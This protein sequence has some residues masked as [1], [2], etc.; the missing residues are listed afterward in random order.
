MRSRKYQIFATSTILVLG[1][2]VSPSHADNA[3]PPK[4][5]SIEQV[6]NGPYSIGEIVTFRINYT[7]G[8]PGIRSIVI[9]GAGSNET[10]LASGTNLQNNGSD[11]YELVWNKDN[12]EKYM[13]LDPILVSAIVVPC[14]RTNG[15]YAGLTIV[16]ETGLQDIVNYYDYYGSNRIAKLKIEVK[17]SDLF[18][19]LGVIKPA[20]IK[21]SISI[22]KI[23][24]NPKANT[25]F[26]LP[27]FTQGG[28]PVV[29]GGSGSCLVNKT[30]FQADLGG[31]LQFTKAGYCKLFAMVLET[32][33]YLFPIFEANI[34]FPVVKFQTVIGTYQVRK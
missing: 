19:P 3:N 13:Y 29:F 7:G 24:K 26:E 4:L 18:T 32:D 34:K 31:T 2:F 15:F 17:P 21:D 11:G 1:F 14:R 6:T 16:D 33:K 28:V 25:K 9:R 20:K 23:P 10:C 30:T 27:K 5:V 8:N 12:N 22:K